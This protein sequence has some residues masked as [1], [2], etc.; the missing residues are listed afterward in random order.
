VNDSSLVRPTISVFDA[1]N[2]LEWVYKGGKE[3]EEM[4]ERGYAWA[5]EHD[6]RIVNK[7][8]IER[9]DKAYARTLRTRNS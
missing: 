2:K 5:K 4:T 9:F 8:W 6:W 1:R 3:V 7:F